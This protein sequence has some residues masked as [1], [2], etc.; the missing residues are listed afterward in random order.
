MEKKVAPHTLT[1]LTIEDL[2]E[3]LNAISTQ[4]NQSAILVDVRT[5]EEFADGHI[6]GSQ[7]FPVDRIGEQVH[8]LSRFS[9]IYIY[10]KSGG[11]VGVACQILKEA[12]IFGL[13]P[14]LQGGFPNWAARGFP[15]EF[16]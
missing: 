12:G 3:K 16:N 4:L 11:R 6:P 5:P 1:P 8:H 10:C 7:N 2:H 9:D 15:I 14:V 13:H